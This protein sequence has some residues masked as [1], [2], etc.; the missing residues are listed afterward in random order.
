MSPTSSG[1]DFE[2]ASALGLQVIWAL[3]LPGKT[4]PVSAGRIVAQTIR[5]ILGQ[6]GGAAHD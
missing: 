1:V 3:S 2:A 4:A 5:E 6:E